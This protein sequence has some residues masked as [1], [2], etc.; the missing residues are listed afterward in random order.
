MM[1]E[2]RYIRTSDTCQIISEGDFTCVFMAVF[3]NY[4]FSDE[5]MP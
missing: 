2:G 4:L 3:L 5:F 1:E